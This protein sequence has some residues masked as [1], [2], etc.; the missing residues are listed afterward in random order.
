MPMPGELRHQWWRDA[1]A[2]RARGEASANP[3]AAAVIDTLDR[4]ELPRE[5]LLA[6]IDARGFDLYDEPMPDMQALRTYCEATSSGLFR[7][8][9]T[10]LDRSASSD[11][12]LQPLPPHET[13]ID[14]AARAAGLA[15]AYTDLISSFAQHAARGQLYLP[16][17]LLQ[18]HGSSS[19]EALS[20]RATPALIAALRD[21]RAEARRHLEVARLAVGSLPERAKPAFRQL[22]LVAPS[23]RSAERAAPE[24][25]LAPSELPQWRKQWA[26]WRG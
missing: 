21:W 7:L 1:L 10:M 26:L 4:R 8:I 18:R 5:A 6:L 11:T 25:F 16:D 3:I 20:G 13:R 22:A 2:G 12:D 17:E 23:L 15:C 24:P 19:E 14:E 9:A